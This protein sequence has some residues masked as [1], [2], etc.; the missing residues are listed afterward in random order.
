MSNCSKFIYFSVECTNRAFFVYSLKTMR[1]LS[2]ICVREMNSSPLL[3][4]H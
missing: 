1:P 4:G 2:A 3:N